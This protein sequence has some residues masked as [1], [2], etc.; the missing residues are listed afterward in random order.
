[1]IGAAVLIAVTVTVLST[2]AKFA[3]VTQLFDRIKW[4]CVLIFMIEYFARVWVCADDR[5]NRY[6]DGW[7]GRFRYMMTPMAIID[8]LAFAPMLAALFVH[9]DA[10]EFLLLRLV[11]LFK[12]LRYF[13]AFETLAVVLSNE[14]KPMLASGILM[15]ILL[16]VM[17]TLGYMVERTAQPDAFGSIPQ[18][19]W[20]GIVTLATI[21]YGDVVPQTVMGKVIGGLTSILGLGMFALPAG[22]VASGFAEEMRRRNFMVTW[23][24]VSSVPFFEHLPASRI[25]E[26][27]SSLEP[28]SAS[29]GEAIIRKGD[30]ADGMYFLIEG[31]CDV[32]I[33]EKPI[34]L[35]DGDFFGEMALLSDR[36]RSASIIAQG[37]TRLL[38][39]RVDHFHRLM[40]NHPD[41]AAAMRKVSDE[42]QRSMTPPPPPIPPANAS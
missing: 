12:L 9:I 38:K 24:L 23:T 29:R 13:S 22:I 11:R 16:I 18:A 26:I 25:A 27:A 1:L 14:R 21:G 15:L 19:M 8:L 10:D 36:P 42:R 7:R 32:M 28:R 35:K 5:Q 34:R 3:D 4:V 33:G 31:E 20:W 39:L 6:N 30:P 37:F 17:S 41:L 2:E 40:A